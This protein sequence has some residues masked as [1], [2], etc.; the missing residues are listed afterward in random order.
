MKCSRSRQRRIR[1]ARPTVFSMQSPGCS[2]RCQ[3]WGSHNPCTGRL[4]HNAVAVELLHRFVSVRRASGRRLANRLSLL[5]AGAEPAEAR[6]PNRHTR[7]PAL[8]CR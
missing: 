4:G 2:F 8:V 3:R 6:S 7:G 1:R 5:L